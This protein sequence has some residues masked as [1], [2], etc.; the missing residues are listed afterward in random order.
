V[1]NYAL[2]LDQGP[3]QVFYYDVDLLVVDVLEQFCAPA[4]I[5]ST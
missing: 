4:L 3:L 1:R 2:V 5:S